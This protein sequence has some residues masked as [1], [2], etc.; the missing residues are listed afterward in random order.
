MPSITPSATAGAWRVLVRKLGSSAVGTSCPWSA[1]KLA[2]P[3]PRTPGVSHRP[4]V[5]SAAGVEE[6]FKAAEVFQ[7][8]QPAAG[9]G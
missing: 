9:R 1:S 2:V 8:P 5:G 3:T 6:V 4:L 7:R